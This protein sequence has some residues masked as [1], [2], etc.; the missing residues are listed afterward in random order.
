MIS[1]FARFGVTMN[2][3]SGSTVEAQESGNLFSAYL[4][5]CR[6]DGQ[7]WGLQLQARYAF[8]PMPA[9]D[10]VQSWNVNKLYGRA[11]INNNRATFD[12][13]LRI[14]QDGVDP[15]TLEDFVVLFKD[16]SNAFYNLVKPQ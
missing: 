10:L 13:V 1:A 6:S 9:P 4:S 15:K 7:C 5:D 16:A 12:M 8:S 2:P 3:V 11:Y 14:P